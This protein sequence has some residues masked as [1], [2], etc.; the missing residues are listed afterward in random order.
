M[1]DGVRYYGVFEDAKNKTD[2]KS[3]EVEEKRKVRMGERKQ[4][5]NRDRFETFVKD[6]YMPYAEE[7]KASWKH[8]EFRSQMLCEYFG[9]KRFDEITVMMVVRFVNTRL[10]SKVSRHRQRGPATRTRSAVTVSKEVT[11]LS[12]I[13]RM[14]VREKAA[15][16]NPVADLPKAVKKKLPHRRR[17]RCALDDAKEVQLI[18]KGLRGRQAYLR[19]IV[20]FD[21]N[22]G[23]RLGELRRLEREHVNLEPDSKWFE[24]NG[25]S[26]EVPQDCLIVTK[27]KNGKPR[28]I[29]LNTQARAIAVH[30]LEDVTIKQYLFQSYKTKSMIKEVKGGLKVACVAAGIKYGQYESDGI[31][32]HTLRHRF[33]SKLAEL[34]VSQTVRRDLLGHSSRDITDD[35]THSTI[36]QRRQAVELLCHTREENLIEFPL[37][38][39][40]NVA[41]A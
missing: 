8:D 5:S 17:R 39:G 29:P 40:K 1:V 6:V 36:E 12:S 41:T 22:T 15:T 7:N 27:S 33:N 23:M 30:Q 32:F 24:I 3:L 31:T 10:A 37:D 16:H 4:G 35:Y 11:L 26:W 38:C 2:A 28:V 18:E 21:L 20:L 9:D 25:E 34:G 19:P 14:A 13:F